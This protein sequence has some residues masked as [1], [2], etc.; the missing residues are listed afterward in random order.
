MTGT[1]QVGG[2][3]PEFPGQRPPFAQGNT[4]A[5]VH[6]ARSP[7][8]VEPI[9]L[10]LRNEAIEATPHLGDARWASELDAWAR[11]E[12]KVVVLMQYESKVGALDEN[13]AP[14]SYLAELDRAEKRAASARDRLGMNPAS[15]A[16]LASCLA[17]AERS[18]SLAQLWAQQATAQD[19]AQTP[20]SGHG[21]RGATQ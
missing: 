8:V 15:A 2:W 1:E 6:G 9:A 7:R 19:A 14:R 16:R 17:G 5:L 4:L 11:A 20:I 21:D 18:M 10:A 3:T 12:A 13:G